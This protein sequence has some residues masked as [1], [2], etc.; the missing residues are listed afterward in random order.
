[1]KKLYI[2]LFALLASTLVANNKNENYLINPIETPHGI[3]LT[4]NF[5]STLYLLINGKLE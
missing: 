2:L 1:M 5:E 4:N 3:L